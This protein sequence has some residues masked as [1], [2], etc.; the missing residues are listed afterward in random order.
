MI[1][2]PF[3]L[4]W[5]S[6]SGRGQ[7]PSH[8][9]AICRRI[10]NFWGPHGVLVVLGGDD[11]RKEFLSAIEAMPQQ[12]R[13]LW[14]DA[15]KRFRIRIEYVS[16]PS[17]AEMFAID[18]ISVVAGHV[19][20]IGAGDA[21]C[22]LMGLCEDELS[23]HIAHIGIEIV[24]VD[25]IDEAESIL[26]AKRLAAAEI[27]RG[28]DRNVL[29]AERFAP[30]I[31]WTRQLVIVDRYCGVDVARHIAT[32]D[33]GLEFVLSQVWTEDLSIKVFMAD[34]RIQPHKDYESSLGAF[35]DAVA[36]VVK[37]LV[38]EFGPRKRALSIFSGPDAAFGQL[39]HDRYLRC[40]SW[41]F[42]LDVGLESFSGR[43]LRR[44]R[45]LCE[46]AFCAP[47]EIQHRHDR[48]RFLQF[49]SSRSIVLPAGSERAVL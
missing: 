14:K 18:D 35:R 19:A 12:T 49:D 8:Q 32:C 40:S 46:L 47:T 1:I 11:G 41:I 5:E 26:A 20:L 34:P 16:A 39:T 37:R 43:G 36:D 44:E 42:K 38:V 45:S 4:D 9:E 48:E 30:L 17:I 10:V 15:L 23:R 28:I 31:P 21:R 2:V 22:D 6:L 25:C 29:W 33:S 3:G 24:R 7:R 27:A 13:K